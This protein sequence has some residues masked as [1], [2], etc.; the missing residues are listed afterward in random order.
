MSDFVRNQREIYASAPP[1]PPTLN[2]K[3]EH[4]LKDSGTRVTFDGGGKK[5]ELDVNTGRFDLIP[6]K[7]MKRLAILYAK[8]AKKYGDRNWETGIPRS[9]LV[10]S[11]L[12]HAH[13][14]ANNQTDEDHLAATIWNCFALIEF[15]GTDW[16]N[17]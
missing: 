11:M 4:G 17:K 5:E 12:R 15:E 13:Q 7:A 3:K 14:A 9:R 1:S 16:E 10:D 6:F 8:G 2:E